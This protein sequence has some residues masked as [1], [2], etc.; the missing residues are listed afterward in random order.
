MLAERLDRC[1]IP[2]LVRSRHQ[3]L[4]HDQTEVQHES[5]QCPQVL[6]NRMNSVNEENVYRN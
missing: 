1:K 3:V 4:D 5:E 2:D 6:V